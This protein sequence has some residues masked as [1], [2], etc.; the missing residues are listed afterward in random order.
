MTHLA[1]SPCHDACTADG[2]RPEIAPRAMLQDELFSRP[3]WYSLLEQTALNQDDRC[4]YFKENQDATACLPLLISGAKPRTLQALSTF[5]TP[6]FGPL[7]TPAQLGPLLESWSAS[8]RQ[9]RGRWDTINL[10]PLDATQPFF[11]LARRALMEA[12]FLVDDYFCFG[13]WFLPCCHPCFDDYFASLPGNTR[14]NIQRAGKRFAR[15]P[16]AALRIVTGTGAELET[17]IC[18]FNTVYAMSWKRP[19]P[20]PDFIPG[21]CRMAAREGWLRLGVATL[22]GK[23]VAA[24][25]W[26]VVD[27]K[28][29]IYK[30][31]YDASL[32]KLSAGTLLTAHLMRHAMDVDQVKEVDYLMGDDAYKKEWM[33]CR[34]ERRGIIAFNL[35]TARGLVAAL[36]HYAGRVVHALGRKLRAGEMQT[37]ASRNTSA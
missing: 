5:Y 11:N 10:A 36:R 14:N 37:G 4:R 17:A 23:A 6:L 21:L 30:L 31:A 19:E 35:R 34:R 13:N 1:T 32:A 16:D 28:A 9:E 7:A 25:I 18:D 8:L 2:G 33:T 27:G 20:Y 22:A 15:I 3:E 26:L 29:M 24:Q 12:G